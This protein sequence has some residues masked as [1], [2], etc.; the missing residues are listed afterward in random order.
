MWADAGVVFECD[1][2]G[3]LSIARSEVVTI[4]RDYVAAA[5]ASHPTSLT[6]GE[7]VRGWGVVGFLL[8]RQ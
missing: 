8:V 5:A 7:G 6:C 2:Q 3:V 4:I 1:L